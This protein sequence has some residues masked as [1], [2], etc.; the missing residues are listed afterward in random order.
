MNELERYDDQIVERKIVDF[1]PP[2]NTEA[3]SAEVIV[4][5]LRRWYIVLIVLVVISAIGLPAVWRLIKPTYVVTGAI[6]VAPIV[7]DL[8][9]GEP[10]SGGIS[11]Y[12]VYMQTQAEKITSDVV[13]ERVA[14][15]LADEELDFFATS[16]PGI[17]TKLK[18]KVTDMRVNPGPVAIL[19]QAI[20]QG[21]ISVAPSRRSQMI[22]VTMS[23]PDSDTARK[24]VDAFIEAYMAAEGRAL[25][26]SDERTLNLLT[27]KR[28]VLLDRM[29]LQR[30]A[31]DQLAQE[32]GDDD[33]SGRQDMNL[34]RVAALWSVLTNVEARRI[35]LETQVQLFK[36]TPV[37]SMQLRDRLAMRSEYINADVE[38]QGLTQQIR[39]LQQDLIVAEQTLS[40][41]NPLLEG[42]RNV[43]NSFRQLREEKHAQLEVEVD[44]MIAEADTGTNGNEL[45]AIQA[46][47]DQ[48]I[49]HEK[50]LRQVLS[51]EDSGTIEIGR[52]RLDIEKKQF[53]LDQDQELY[54]A[55]CLRIS[56]LEME[57]ERPPRITVG[58]RAQLMQVQDKRVKLSAAIVFCGLAA[59]MLLAFLRDKADQRL[60]SPQDVTKHIGI[61]IIGTTTSP[62]SVKKALL[63]QQVIE[64]Y[65]TIRAN[66]GLLNG[67]GI[68][69]KLV[70]TS[71]SVSEGKTT[72][73]INL[74]TSIAKSGK[75]VLLID[76]DLRKPD[77]ARLLNLPK[78]SR[79]LQDLLFGTNG[80]LAVHSIASTGLDVLTAD[81]RN[82][83]D[84][85]EL[86]ALPA[87]AQRIDAICRN[88][89][90]VIIDT[91][92]V[93]SF[94]DALI[95]AKMADAVL[96]TSF[97][98]QTTAGDLRETKQKL[99][100]IN[101]NVLG[102]ILT[103][104]PITQSYY[105]Y[106]Y[107]YYAKNSNKRN[108]ST[109]AGRKLL[110]PAESTKEDKT[111][112]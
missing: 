44:K 75:R 25:S 39:T 34:S 71:S 40:P 22:L 4:G 74:A 41:K 87:T 29:D 47:L 112:S 89:D 96:L 108:R 50:R 100:Q 82:R 84:A 6:E 53:K 106:G 72:L 99:A 85:C 17:V 9:T 101:A 16:S 28:K 20:N 64:D 76:G 92:P 107:G 79:G 21:T 109:K 62:N 14:D 86:L 88:Y 37:Q 36:E 57:R 49:A 70:V 110:L 52:K 94:P 30:G 2:D 66:L 68:P 42:K 3:N 18:Q 77:I 48:A 55:M 27:E 35:S 98:G 73:S 78:E 102:T 38:L 97:T 51:E 33:L 91:P 80:E 61:R 1:A 19:R 103:N 104:V 56:E 15:N 7:E 43:L 59:G 13:L 63:P 12:Q 65:Q 46:K 83:L 10:D 31:I 32:Y 111:K 5:I 81:T 90:H 105:R 67:K 60:R 45:Q 11:N 95:W 93:L 58:Y 54:N 69:A 26:Q 24:I 8:L 23:G